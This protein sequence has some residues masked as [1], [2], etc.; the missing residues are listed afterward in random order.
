MSRNADNRTIGWREEF[1]VQDQWT[2][3]LGIRF[4]Q[5]QGLTHDGQISPR[6]GVSYAMTPN[7]VVHA[8]Y[9]RLFTP[10]NLEAVQFAQLGTVGTT[11][12]PENLTNPAVEPERAHY[13]E[14]GSAHAIGDSVTVELTCF[15]KLS[16]FFS[17]AG[18]FGTTL[19]LNYF[20]FERGRQRGVDLSIKAKFFIIYRVGEMW[21]RGTVEARNCNR[22][23]SF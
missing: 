14:L 4:D 15:Y 5:I 12:E 9:G 8:F 19:L 17:D 13:F 22:D 11:A 10:P 7:H 3:N 2:F 23:I 6:L 16:N 18:Q 21:F 1:W 20:A